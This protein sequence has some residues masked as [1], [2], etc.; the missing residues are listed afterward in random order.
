MHVCCLCIQ[1]IDI[2]SQSI[3]LLFTDKINPYKS[4]RKLKKKTALPSLSI[5]I[6]D[7]RVNIVVTISEC[8][9]LCLAYLLFAIVHGNWGEWGAWSSCSTTC[10]DGILTRYRSCD[11]PTPANGGSNCQG[12]N[13]QTTSCITTPCPGI[14]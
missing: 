11:N 9:I 6:S 8:I 5:S 14:Y 3:P 4:T 2:S 1:Y 12:S 13:K 10:G 7:D